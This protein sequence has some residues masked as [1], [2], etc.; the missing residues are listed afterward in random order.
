MSSIN[1]RVHNFVNADSGMRSV[2]SIDLLSFRHR[3]QSG[4]ASPGAPIADRRGGLKR[5][6]ARSKKAGEELDK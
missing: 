6:P 3:V 1:L 4:S 2:I 5:Q